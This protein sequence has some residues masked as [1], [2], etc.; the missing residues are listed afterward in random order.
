MDVKFVHRVS[1]IGLGVDVQA[2]GRHRHERVEEAIIIT[3]RIFEQSNRNDKR[4]WI[5]RRQNA[6]STLKMRKTLLN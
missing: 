6:L 2:L 5:S 1:I 3:A 4:N